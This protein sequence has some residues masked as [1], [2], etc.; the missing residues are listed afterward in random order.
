M[1][2]Y[3]VLELFDVLFSPLPLLS[4][5]LCFNLDNFYLPIFK[6]NESTL[7]GVKFSDELIEGIHL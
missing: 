2:I 1:M 6:F 3:I 5:S 4:F 7:S